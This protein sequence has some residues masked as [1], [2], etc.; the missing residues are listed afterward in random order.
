MMD[1]DKKFPMSMYGNKED[2]YKAKAEYYMEMCNSL[3]EQN[4][5][6]KEAMFDLMDLYSIPS[7]DELMEL[8][9]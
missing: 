9:K 4:K 7:N 5:E 2:L 6:L 3:T 8:L 1:I